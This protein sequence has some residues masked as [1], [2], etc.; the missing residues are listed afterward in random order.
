MNTGNVFSTLL[1][2][3]VSAEE[4]N[5]RHQLS[6]QRPGYSHLNPALPATLEPRLLSIS[7]PEYFATRRDQLPLPNGAQSLS[8]S[9]SYDTVYSGSVSRISIE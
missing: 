4:E 9:G 2:G 6:Q 3:T 7:N 5:S 1:T 8:R